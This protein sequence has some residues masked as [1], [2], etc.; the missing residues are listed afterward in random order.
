MTRHTMNHQATQEPASAQQGE[1]SRHAGKRKQQALFDRALI[2]SALKDALKK[3]DPRVQWRNPV[4]FV[5]YLGS[6]P[7]S[8][9][10]L[11][12]PTN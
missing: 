6:M 3:L 9:T 10:H 2:R 8:Y 4:M 1:A 5:V 12:L 11:T 7:V